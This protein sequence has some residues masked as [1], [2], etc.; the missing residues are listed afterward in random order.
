MAAGAIADVAAPAAQALRAAYIL[1][2]IGK[3]RACPMCAATLA[4]LVRRG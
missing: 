3:A 2:A 1:D 4:G